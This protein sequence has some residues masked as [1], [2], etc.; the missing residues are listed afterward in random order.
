MTGAVI[1]KVK[2]GKIFKI[3][4]PEVLQKMDAGKKIMT[5]WGLLDKHK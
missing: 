3:Q 1:R 4:N 2:E 5:L